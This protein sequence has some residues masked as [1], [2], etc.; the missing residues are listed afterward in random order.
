MKKEKKTLK[1]INCIENLVTFLN[2]CYNESEH[3]F[4]PFT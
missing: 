2:D 3:I 1:K 4:E